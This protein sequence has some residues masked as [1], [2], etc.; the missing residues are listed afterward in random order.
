MPSMPAVLLSAAIGLIAVSGAHA[1]SART[2][3]G[4]FSVLQAIGITLGDCDLNNISLADLHRVIDLCGAPSTM[5]SETITQ[6]SIK[7]IASDKKMELSEYHAYGAPMYKVR[8]V[9]PQ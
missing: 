2:C 7:V 9:L 1:Q 8:K 3:S 4:E 5:E 6:C